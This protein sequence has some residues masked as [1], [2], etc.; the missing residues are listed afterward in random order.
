M[1]TTLKLDQHFGQSRYHIP[2]ELIRL[3]PVTE[4]NII[5]INTRC[6]YFAQYVVTPWMY[7][8][9]IKTENIN[10]DEKGEIILSYLLA[11]VRT[12]YL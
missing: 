10:I 8:I 1:P 6:R 5:Y 2:T 11:R 12:D 4:F 9:S 3:M 7:N